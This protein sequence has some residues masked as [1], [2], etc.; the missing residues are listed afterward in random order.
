MI[1]YEVIEDYED[2]GMGAISFGLFST[3]E[4]ANELLVILKDINGFGTCEEYL[5]IT[6][7]EIVPDKIE[8]WVT[9]LI[10]HG[11]ERKKKYI[12]KYGEDY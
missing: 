12:E 8:D 2:E 6:E 5:R 4:K 11:K 10:Q 3:Y 1:L 9:N 7:R